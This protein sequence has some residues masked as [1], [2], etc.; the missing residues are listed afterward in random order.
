MYYHFLMTLLNMCSGTY[1]PSVYLSGLDICSFFAHFIMLVLLLLS[2]SVLGFSCI[3]DT[4]ALSDMCFANT[5][6]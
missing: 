5:F 6:S 1:L 3:L 2:C 4:N